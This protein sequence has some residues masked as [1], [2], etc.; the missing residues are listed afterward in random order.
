MVLLIFLRAHQPD[1]AFYNFKFVASLGLIRNVPICSM[2]GWIEGS[3]YIAQYPILTIAQNALHFASLADLNF[4]T[5]ST[6]LE[7]IQPYATINAQRL[8]V[9]ISTTVYSQALVQLSELEQCRVKKLAQGKI[10][11]AARDSNLGPLSRKSEA[12]PLSN[13]DYCY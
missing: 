5:I 6:S 2:N 7:S 13:Y 10:Y 8:L 9:Y 4:S 1:F 3:S 12:L 11:T